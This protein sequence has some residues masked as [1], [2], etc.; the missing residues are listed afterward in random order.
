MLS[1][2]V[3][4]MRD[5]MQLA[6]MQSISTELYMVNGHA[7]DRIYKLLGDNRITR[8]LSISCNDE[9]QDNKLSEGLTAFLEK[10]KEIQQRKLLIEGVSEN[11]R[12]SRDQ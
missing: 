3:K 10:E 7:T 4:V 8:W 6:E 12:T 11:Q 9:L 2:T 1:K 5:L